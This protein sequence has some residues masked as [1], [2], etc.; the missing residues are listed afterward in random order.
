MISHE[1]GKTMNNVSAAPAHIKSK[2]L[3]GESGQKSNLFATF[4]SYKK[5]KVSPPR[6]ELSISIQQKWI[7]T[8]YGSDGLPAIRVI[9]RPDNVT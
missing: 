1:T 2:C 4:E 3:V 6:K 8:A 5:Q 7:E 9:H